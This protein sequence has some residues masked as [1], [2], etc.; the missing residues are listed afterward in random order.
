MKIAETSITMKSSHTKSEL[1][2]SNESLKFIAKSGRITQRVSVDH[3]L[4]QKALGDYY[5]FSEES[6]N[7]LQ[8]S[9]ASLISNP[10]QD[11]MDLINSLNLPDKEKQK[12]LALM[13]F[14]K[15]ITGKDLKVI[16]PDNIRFSSSYES[17]QFKINL[18]NLRNEMNHQAMSFNKLKTGPIPSR[19]S[20]SGF[21]LNY[22]Q[23]EIH[24]E[25]ESLSFNTTGKV[26]TSDGKEISLDITLN[27]S[28]YYAERSSTTI[29]AGNQKL[30]DPIVINYDAPAATF[31]NS[32]FF[33]DIDCNGTPDQIS[34]L[35]KG[36]GFLALD[37]NND[38]K[39]N[40]GS[41]L[42]GTKSGDGFSDLKQYDSDGNG[43]IDEN[44]PV[45]DKLRIWSRNDD[46][47]SSL[48]ALGQK[49]IGAIYVGSASADFDYKDSSNT[50]QAKSRKAGVFL[51]EDGSSGIV[52][53]ID[54]VV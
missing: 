45:Y 44:D 42:F 17:L 27:M 14:V 32:K 18:M 34:N 47:S 49:G 53:Q 10:Q 22:H 21:A 19:S 39:I 20:S 4:M 52:Q 40:D 16:L 43:W 31:S 33:F 36:S 11:E 41:E 8:D 28:R 37:K 35:S 9:S 30:L 1:T 46:G 2:K 48:I 29:T 54:Y 38:G 25:S 50:L 51:K 23:N 6:K 7:K 26:K 5:E 3:S 15:T 24:T 13:Q 12:L